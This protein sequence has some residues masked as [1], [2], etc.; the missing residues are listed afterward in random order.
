MATLHT[1]Q[2]NPSGLTLAAAI[3][4]AEISSLQNRL[5]HLKIQQDGLMSEVEQF[6]EPPPRDTI[7]RLIIRQAE[8]SAFLQEMND[9][10]QGESFI[11]SAM[12]TDGS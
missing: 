12:L 7:L 6:L 10:N 3:G 4:T 5:E 1:I 2:R 9:L 8:L 11:S